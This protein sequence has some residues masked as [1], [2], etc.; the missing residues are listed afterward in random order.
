M[1]SICIILATA[2]IIIG[3][4]I[5]H[6]TKSISK[7]RQGKNGRGSPSTPPPLPQRRSTQGIA[8]NHPPQP[9]IRIF[10]ESPPRLPVRQSVILAKDGPRNLSTYKYPCCP[11]DKAR[12]VE[13]EPQRIFWDST[14]QCYRCSKNHIFKLNGR[15]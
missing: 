13:G 12:N 1:I 5:Y 7:T 6:M 4:I 3:I 8:V 10:S 14:R 15:L 9:R 11:I 2:L